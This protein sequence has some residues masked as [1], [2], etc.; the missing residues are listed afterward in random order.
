MT[1]E[2]IKGTGYGN[3]G[4]IASEYEKGRHNYPEEI[5]DYCWSLP[6]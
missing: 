3:F 6:V 1:K 4:I 5:I 2:V